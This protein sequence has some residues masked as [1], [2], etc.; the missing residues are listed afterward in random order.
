[1]TSSTV[2]AVCTGR[3]TDLSGLGRTHH[4]AFV[5][6]PVEGPVRLG[7]L[8]L[9]GD[10]QA[11]HDHG[12]SD[13]AL[14]VYSHDHYAFWKERLGLNLPGAGAMAENLTVDGLTEETV[15]IGDVFTIGDARV[16]ITSPRGPCFKL[17]ARY[18]S[19]EL[20]RVMQETSWTGYLMRVLEPGTIESGQPMTLVERPEDSMTVAE[21]AR[22]V[23]RDRS[24]WD[25]VERLTA[26]PSLAEAMRI[27]LQ[28]RLRRRDGGSDAARLYGDD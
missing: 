5:K 11:Y 17:A 12:G 15:H 18:E 6:D 13:Q 23:N 21:A 1:V 25:V 14:L 19:R 26:I 16:Q 2:L 7:V 27:K 20:P 28:A 9:E 22:V 10:E 4:S 24:D 3:A 8:G